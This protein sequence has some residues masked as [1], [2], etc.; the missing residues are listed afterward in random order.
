MNVNII[1]DKNMHKYTKSK[2]LAHLL[3]SKYFTNF[4]Y[5]G[6]IISSTNILKFKVFRAS[7]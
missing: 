3:E 7:K 1:D 5:L 2:K 6:K 4:N